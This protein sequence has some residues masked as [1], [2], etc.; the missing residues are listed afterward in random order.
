MAGRP[1]DWPHYGVLHAALFD[2]V[3]A[4]FES[5]TD[6]PIEF[7]SRYLLEQQQQDWLK[8]EEAAAIRIEAAFRGRRARRSPEDADTQT[9]LLVT[10]DPG[11]DLDDEMFIVLACTLAARGLVTLCGVVTCLAPAA[12]RAR[13]ARGTLD[14]L[15]MTHVPTAAGTDGGASGDADSIA[16]M[17]SIEYITKLQ[18]E[19]GAGHTLMVQ[20]HIHACCMHACMRTCVEYVHGRRLQVHVHTC[21]CMHEYTRMHA[22]A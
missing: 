11:Q 6:A 17:A 13:L 4:A 14:Q 16:N 1:G 22:P 5:Q 19:E 21:R 15:G 20:V 9:R 10:M 3:K 8:T 12:M 7:V 18:P 2:A